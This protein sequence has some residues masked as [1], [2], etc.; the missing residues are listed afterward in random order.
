MKADQEIYTKEE[1]EII[2]RIESGEYTSLPK[3]EFEQEKLRFQ[4]MATNTMR[5]Q[6]KNIKFHYK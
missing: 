3:D 1:L 5:R 6:T 2:H 4:A